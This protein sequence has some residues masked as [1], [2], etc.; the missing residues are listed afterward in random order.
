MYVH[1][2]HIDPL[3]T[4]ST[5]PLDPL[6]S[7]RLSGVALAS[8]GGGIGNGGCYRGADHNITLD[9]PEGRI[10]TPQTPKRAASGGPRPP[11]AV[12]ELTRCW[13]A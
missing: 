5:P 2:R 8:F 9:S 4:P 7:N 6:S 13:G 11:L 1:A 12:K 3:C 10:Q